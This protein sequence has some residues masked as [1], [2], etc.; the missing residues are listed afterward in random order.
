M[1]TDA[2]KGC[3][4]A[5]YLVIAVLF[6]ILGDAYN[7]NW[8][9]VFFENEH[10]YTLIVTAL[11]YTTMK[12]KGWKRVLEIVMI[13]KLFYIAF[14]IAVL[15]EPFNSYRDFTSNPVICVQILWC[16]IGFSIFQLFRK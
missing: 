7:V 9:A 3:I 16:I 14:N 4:A 8:Y 10:I 12:S 13:W 11:L 5:I 6:L 2:H 1:V 15:F